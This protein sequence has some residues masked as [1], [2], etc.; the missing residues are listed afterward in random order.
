MGFLIARLFGLSD[1]AGLL[2]FALLAPI[3]AVASYATT[4]GFTAFNSL[5]EY[6][7]P[8]NAAQASTIYG[9]LNGEPVALATF[10]HENRVS[11]D[12]DQMS[13][14]MINAVISTE[15][16][17]FFKHVGVD[18]L[19]LTRATLGVASRGLS[20][21]GG[22]TITMQYIKNSLI[23]AAN[24]AGDKEALEAATITTIDR[25]IREIR[26]AMALE[27][28]TS[29]E[30]ILAGYLN[31]SFFGN[32]LNGIESASNYYF[33]V[34]AKD[35]TVPQAALLTAMLRAPNDYKPDEEKNLPDAKIRRDYVIN[36][37]R[38]EGFITSAEAEAYK[39][40]PVVANITP[41]ATG[42]EANQSTSYFCDYVVWTIRNSPE[43]GET[44]EDREML[45]RRGGLEIYTSMD[46]A[47]QNTTDEVVKR[48]V[49]VDNQW[50]LGAASV[51][52]EVSTGRVLA[53]SQNRLFSQI[54]DEDPTTTSVNYSTD[55]A[56]GGSSGFQTGSTYKVFVLAEWLSKGF[57][58]GDRVDARNKS[59]QE[60][61]F[62]AK[63]G[64][65][66]GGDWE[67]GNFGGGDFVNENILSATVSSINTAYVN[68]AAQLDLCDIRDMAERFG[69]KRSDGNPLLYV[70]SSVLG[71]NELS[72]LSMAAA[73]A[74]FANNGI[75]CSPIA[76]DKVVIRATGEELEVPVSESSRAVSSEVAAAVTYS[77]ERVI[78]GGTATRS[79]IND[80]VPIAGKTGT[81]DETIQSWMTGYSSKVSTATWVGNVVGK[82]SLNRTSIQGVSGNLVRHDIWRQI[83]AQAN[84]T[85]GG[86]SFTPAS[87]LYLGATTVAMPAINALLPEVAETVLKGAGLSVQVADTTVPSPNA[88]GSIAY[89]NFDE[90][91]S[92]IR[93]SLVTLF[94]SKGGMKAIPN[95]AGK[96]VA[97]AKG[98]LSSA[99]FLGV[100]EPVPSQAEYFV[101]SDSVADGN[102]VGT[103]PESGT[104]IELTEGILLKISKGPRT[105]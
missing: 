51:S 65:L 100:A 54:T 20:G 92:V 99:G 6:I 17:R 25:K 86:D 98:I 14:N 11:I 77:L 18:I 93:G 37:M 52:M 78:T 89:A 35:L 32:Q 71:V 60:R 70:P 28:V 43:F 34:K 57:L 33:G 101:F 47:L 5:A 36:N 62:K 19:S 2:T 44:P 73:M 40:E 48:E 9:N 16:P 55:K 102:V 74:G 46:L 87:S 96:T 97:E 105:G 72:P 69:I 1:I 81:T 38:D 68:M 4:T 94:V 56:T 39:K 15:D 53:M 29:K 12:Y 61:E 88:P 45:L 41:T 104:F 58:L 30:D 24:I 22:S 83:M 50:A 82:Q 8:V 10:Y 63:C 7:K 42:C 3:A 67:P 59:W 85:Y 64:G 31:L 21:P 27:T 26:F 79:R 66:G 75:Y 76:I 90:G 49:P 91:S 13:T 80:G 103:F 84:A 23:E 95:V